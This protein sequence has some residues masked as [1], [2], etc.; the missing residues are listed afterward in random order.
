MSIH[1]MKLYALPLPFHVSLTLLLHVINLS[2]SLDIVQLHEGGMVRLNVHLHQVHLVYIIVPGN[3][4][5]AVIQ[6]FVIKA[7][8]KGMLLLVHYTS[9]T[10]S[11]AL[12]STHSFASAMCLIQFFMVPSQMRLHS[13]LCSAPR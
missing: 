4:T 8:Y 6:E 10:F 3:I 7:L 12:T 13:S 5:V 11:M 1:P 2:H 9:H